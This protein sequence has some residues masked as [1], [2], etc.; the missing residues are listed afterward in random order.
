[1]PIIEIE[2]HENAP[3]ERCFDLSRSIDFH[4]VST[5]HTSERATAGVTTG[6]IGAGDTVTFQ[7]GHLGLKW[8][9]TSRIVEFE[10]PNKFTDEMLKGPFKK[11]RHEHIFREHEGGTLMIDR[12]DMESP[13]GIAGK[14]FDRLVLDNYM[15]KFLKQRCDA[16]KECLESGE[17]RKYV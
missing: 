15:R 2:T 1:M 14:I 3:I 10:K 16:V 11:L 13:A 17:W 4:I 7:A 12:M 6:L 5:E 9:L 8:K